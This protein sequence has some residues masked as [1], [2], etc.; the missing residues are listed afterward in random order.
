MS[1]EH[2]E[3]HARQKAEAVCAL[4]ALNYQNTLGWG[5]EEW[6][7]FEVLKAKLRKRVMEAEREI[8]NYIKGA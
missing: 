4:A 7:K 2:L 8:E 3:T 6:A 5:P 1:E